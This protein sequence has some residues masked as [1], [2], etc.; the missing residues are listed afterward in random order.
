[1]RTVEGD[2]CFA[3]FVFSDKELYLCFMLATFKK[4]FFFSK[5]LKAVIDIKECIA[6]KNKYIFFIFWCVQLFKNNS[7]TVAYIY[8]KFYVKL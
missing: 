1:M 3:N 7:S 6:K 2:Q 5:L 4:V 8:N